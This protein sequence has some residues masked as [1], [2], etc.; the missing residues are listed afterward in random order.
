MLP[1][2]RFVETNDDEENMSIQ[3]KL[4]NRIAPVKAPPKYLKYLGTQEPTQ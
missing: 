3:G 4:V 1:L 2:K